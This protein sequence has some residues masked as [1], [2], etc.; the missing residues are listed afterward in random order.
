MQEYWFVYYK[1]SKNMACWPLFITC[2]IGRKAEETKRFFFVFVFLYSHDP[3]MTVLGT[4]GTLHILYF[5]S[6]NVKQYS[7]KGQKMSNY[8]TL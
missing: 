4:C 8:K 3:F 6:I 5:D 7:N 1:T 2:S